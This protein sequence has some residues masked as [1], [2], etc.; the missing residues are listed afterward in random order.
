MGKGNYGGMRES[1]RVG[2][3]TKVTIGGVLENRE[4]FRVCARLDRTLRN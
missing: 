4:C 3:P 1:E 2:Q